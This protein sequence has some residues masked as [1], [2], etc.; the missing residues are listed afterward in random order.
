MHRDGLSGASLGSVCAAIVSLDSKA[1]RSEAAGA[2]VSSKV[3]EPSTGPG[4]RPVLR[5]MHGVTVRKG[6]R[7]KFLQ[8][9]LGGERWP[10]GSAQ[11]PLHVVGE[12]GQ[13]EYGA[14]AVLKPVVDGM[15]PVQLLSS[16]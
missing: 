1:R 10:P 3:P 14:H 13:D 2:V 16:A 7:V 9:L 8:R 5:A 15:G 11:M 6:A 4:A 12:H